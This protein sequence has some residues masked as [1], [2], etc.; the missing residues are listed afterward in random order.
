[1]M[2]WLIVCV[3]WHVLTWINR[4]IGVISLH[5]L[6]TV[7]I[8]FNVNLPFWEL[9]INFLDDLGTYLIGAFDH[10]EGVAKPIEGAPC[11]TL[12]DP[13]I[14]VKLPDVSDFSILGECVSDEWFCDGERELSDI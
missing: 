1:M 10:G 3:H 4:T 6:K 12:N 11:I 2:R 5:I 8:S 7:I 14:N 9:I 13:E